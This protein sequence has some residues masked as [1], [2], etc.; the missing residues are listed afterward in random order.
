MQENKRF[1][2]EKYQ[3]AIEAQEKL[4]QER[5]KSVKQGDDVVHLVY[6]GEFDDNELTEVNQHLVGAGLRL[7]SYNKNGIITANLELYKIISQIV[8]SQPLLIEILKGV[9]PNAIWDAIKI[10]TVMLWRISIG[11]SFF[12]VTRGNVES[13][14]MTFGVKV[15]LDANTT[16]DFELKGDVSQEVIAES[17]DKM[18]DF[19]KQQQPKL[20]HQ[21]ED[22]VYYVPETKQWIKID[23]ME[24]IQKL[25][26]EKTSKFRPSNREA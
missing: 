9:G 17:L 13:R 18:L 4:I 24:A 23:V 14:E 26:E 6:M 15:K 19:I 3:S 1:D 5:M 8:I 16:F 20:K 7:S 21:I 11:K 22:Y 12:K 10:A 2:D 25:G